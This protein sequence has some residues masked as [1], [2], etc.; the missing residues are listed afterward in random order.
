MIIVLQ[1]TKYK[2]G[3]ISLLVC[4]LSILLRVVQFDMDGILLSDPWRKWSWG[5]ICR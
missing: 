1:M 3:I 5:Y 4:V 2:M